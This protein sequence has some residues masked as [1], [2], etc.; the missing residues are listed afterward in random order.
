MLALRVTSPSK[1]GP[2]GAD[3]RAAFRRW[4]SANSHRRRFCSTRRVSADSSFVG[5]YDS[6]LGFAMHMLSSSSC[7]DFPFSVLVL[8]RGGLEAD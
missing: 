5:G 8:E 4:R 1:D 7:F 2:P 6:E 3:S